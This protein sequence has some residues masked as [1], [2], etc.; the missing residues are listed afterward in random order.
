MSAVICL[1][2]VDD[3]AAAAAAFAAASCCGCCS[4]C[5]ALPG[6]RLAYLEDLRLP[7]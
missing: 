1:G 6:P 7:S 2:R 3:A 5:A 4:E